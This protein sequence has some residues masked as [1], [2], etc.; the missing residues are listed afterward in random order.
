MAKVT[1]E[2][3]VGGKRIN[4]FIAHSQPVRDEIEVHTAIIGEHARGIKRRWRDT[5]ASYVE[6]EVAKLDG[7]VIL[8]D[9]RGI[10]GAMAMEYGSDPHKGFP[11]GTPAQ[12]ILH[13]AAGIEIKHT[14]PRSRRRKKL[15]RWRK[16]RRRR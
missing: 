12:A 7:Y 8:N 3:Y 6:T 11:D 9:T 10:K 4:D 2:R 5:G 14:H 1:M 13:E 16:P 15:Y